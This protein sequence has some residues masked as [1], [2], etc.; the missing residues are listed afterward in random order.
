MFT[1]RKKNRITNQFFKH[2]VTEETV[3]RNMNFYKIIRN[4]NE[5]AIVLEDRR[6]YLIYKLI[7]VNFQSLSE[8]LRDMTTIWKGFHLYDKIITPKTQNSL[9]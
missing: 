5:H 2:C 8:I 1:S 3:S 4:V 9:F 7:V 6:L